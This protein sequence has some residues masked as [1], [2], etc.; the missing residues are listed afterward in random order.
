MPNDLDVIGSDQDN[1]LIRYFDEEFDDKNYIEIK[2]EELSSLGLGAVSSLMS[3]IAS[4]GIST[5]NT[6]GVYRVVFKTGVND[7]TVA[8]L[9]TN[10]EGKPITTYLE[11]GRFQQA[12]LDKVG[13]TANVI[14]GAMSIA[15]FALGCYYM[16]SINKQM[17]S[18][19]NKF[20]ELRAD[21]ENEKVL[22][23]KETKKFID[24]VVR[25][26]N[27]GYFT[28]NQFDVYYNEAMTERKIVYKIMEHYK[29]K[30]N[31]FVEK[32]KDCNSGFCENKQNRYEF[33]RYLELYHC[34]AN[35]YSAM[36]TV[37]TALSRNTSSGFLE[38]RAKMLKETADEYR[39]NIA[40]WDKLKKDGISKV[41]QPLSNVKGGFAFVLEKTIDVAE[42]AV[43]GVEK[44]FAGGNNDNLKPLKDRK[45]G[46]KS[47]QNDN[48]ANDEKKRCVYNKTFCFPTEKSNIDTKMFTSFANKTKAIQNGDFAIC[49]H[50][51]K[52]YIDN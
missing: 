47:L 23:L 13:Q 43:V 44:I 25:G 31:T 6:S 52:M 12:G 24:E 36:F 28:E 35:A 8:D 21:F 9:L 7:K 51:G 38:D 10:S 17:T 45:N 48:A 42:G 11:N 34:S 39:E 50:N 29:D 1:I 3:E 4:M 30:L 40:K 15:S 37:E 5:M 32:F 27:G 18:L 16:N 33:A 14:N 46:G 19:D 26:I 22:D 41:K 2:E 20:D 49:Y